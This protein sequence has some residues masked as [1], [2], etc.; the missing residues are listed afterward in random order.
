VNEDI[1]RK[2]MADW[3]GH[4][5]LQ[6]AVR[7]ID[8]YH[9]FELTEGAEGA[10]KAQAVLGDAIHELQHAAKPVLYADGEPRMK[11]PVEFA[12]TEP[13]RLASGWQPPP[14]WK[15]EN[16]QANLPLDTMEN[17]GVAIAVWAYT[18]SVERYYCAREEPAP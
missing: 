6:A 3:I 4:P 11:F 17:Y 2:V 1:G 5:L 10:E 12:E 16:G 7:V 15:I 18:S 14:P 13:E 9:G 8:A